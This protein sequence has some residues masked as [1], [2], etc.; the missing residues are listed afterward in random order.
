MMNKT[1]E[2]FRYLMVPKGKY[3]VPVKNLKTSKIQ[4][5]ACGVSLNVVLHAEG[6][7]LCIT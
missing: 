5:I 1:T 3:R 6:D 7:Y 4:T 2:I